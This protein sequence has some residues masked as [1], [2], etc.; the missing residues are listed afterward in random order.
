MCLWPT[1]RTDS[2]L[3][4]G[5]GTRN[6]FAAFLDGAV[7]AAAQDAGATIEVTR[8]PV[9]NIVDREPVYTSVAVD[10]RLNE[11]VLY[12][13]NTWSMRFFNRTD[14][15]PPTAALTEPKRVVTGP[16]SRIQF[17]SDVYIDPKNGDIYTVENDIGKGLYVFSPGAGGD[18]EPVRSLKFAVHRAYAI[19]VDEEKQELFVTF[20]APPKVEVYRKMA[21][22]DEKPLRVLQGEHTRLAD[23]H[24]IALDVKNGLMFVNNWGNY[25]D[26]TVGG[27]FE[28][29]SIAV[30]PLD[31]RGDTPPLRVI[32]GPKTRLNWPGIMSFDP[33]TGDLTVANTAGQSILV[34]RGSDR[35]D[36]APARVIEGSKTGLSYPLGLTIDSKNKE[37]WIAN[38]GNASATVYPLTANGDVAPLRT[39]RSAPRNKVSLRF[40][41]TSTVA[42]DSKREEIL[43]P[44]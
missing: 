17:N 12:D 25:S 23:A 19:T 9:R 36:V 43:V 28:T 40:G 22:G 24:G 29:P 41:K 3:V 34:F 44:N 33:A 13:S 39:I 27:R 18:A 14:N 32:Q 4:A 21:S 8:P 16:R 20:Q 31:A 42:Y 30:Y 26:R 2:D 11:V 1:A 7:H 5:L 38:V 10:T 15:T 37:L 6:L 35:G